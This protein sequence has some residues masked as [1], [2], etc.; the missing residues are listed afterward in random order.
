MSVDGAMWLILVIFSSSIC[1]D[2]HTCLYNP[3]CV[4][5]RPLVISSRPLCGVVAHRGLFSS[6]KCDVVIYFISFCDL[7]RL[8]FYF[9]QFMM[10]CGVAHC[11]FSSVQW[12]SSHVIS[13]R[14][15]YD[16]V[17]R[18]FIISGVV[19]SV[20]RLVWNCLTLGNTI[21]I[22]YCGKKENIGQ[23]PSNHMLG[24]HI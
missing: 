12:Y 3:L 16:V 23:F 9:L 20:H 2:A 21:P 15:W 7:K 24:I 13:L 14:L 10:W 5:Y 8:I 18:W 4:C 11:W 1:A 6:A 22:L 19:H 17:H